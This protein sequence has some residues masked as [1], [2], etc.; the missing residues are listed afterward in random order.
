MM[1]LQSYFKHIVV[2]FMAVSCGTCQAHP[3]M[4]YVPHGIKLYAGYFIC[5]SPHRFLLPC[6]TQ[7]DHIRENLIKR[8]KTLFRK[9]MLSDN[10]IIK[11]LSVNAYFCNS[12]DDLNWKFFNMYEKRALSEEEESLSGLLLS[13][14]KARENHWYIPQCDID[15]INEMTYHM[16]LFIDFLLN[17]H[18][19]IFVFIHCCD[20]DARINYW[21]ELNWLMI[22]FLFGLFQLLMMTCWCWLFCA[23]PLPLHD[24]DLIKPYCEVYFFLIYS[25]IE[26]CELPF[27]SWN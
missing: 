24:G 21:I 14:L 13:L 10:D 8:S 3:S 23:K 22:M 5:H 9:M 6:V 2:H 15:E 20:V 7:S 26:P 4:T 27:S 1:L 19:Y 16:Y 11:F 12:P 25:L 18:L 17:P